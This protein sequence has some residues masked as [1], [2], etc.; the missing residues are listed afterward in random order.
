MDV[1]RDN[2]ELRVGSVRLIV[3]VDEIPDVMARINAARP[4]WVAVGSAL[5]Y[6]GDDIAVVPTFKGERSSDVPFTSPGRDMFAALAESLN[7]SSVGRGVS[8]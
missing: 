8:R 6:A 7:A 5:F 2:V 4:G 3:P 1:D